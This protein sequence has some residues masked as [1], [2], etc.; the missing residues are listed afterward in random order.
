MTRFINRPEET[1]VR[2]TRVHL[3]QNMSAPM[4]QGWGP[5]L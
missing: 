3:P 4:F 1:E 5:K 2:E